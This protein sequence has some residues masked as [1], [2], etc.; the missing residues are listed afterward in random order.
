MPRGQ[1]CGARHESGEYVKKTSSREDC[2]SELLG[3]RVRQ[4]TISSVHLQRSSDRIISCY[5]VGTQ[6][7]TEKGK[8]SINTAR[9]VTLF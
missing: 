2:P 7:Q 4:S 6:R 8:I 3:K 1:S 5:K 9:A